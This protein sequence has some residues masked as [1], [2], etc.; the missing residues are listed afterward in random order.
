[1][2]DLVTLIGVDGANPL[3]FMASLGLLRVIRDARKSGRLSFSDDGMF[4]ARV[5]VD[6][7]ART[8]PEL[9]ADD[10]AR[11]AGAA[12]LGLRY[13]KTEKNGTKVVADLKAPPD[14]FRSFMEAAIEAW[15]T[16]NLDPAA[17]ATAFGTSEARDG[18]GVSTKPTAFHF[19]AANQTFL[20]IAEE[21]RGRVTADWARRS[22]FE[23]FAAEPGK[24]LRWDPGADRNWALM[25][26]NPNVEGTQ[27][28]APL[29]WL[30]VR[31][32]AL[33]PT[34]PVKDRIVT[35]AVEGTRADD[36]VFAW[37]MWSAPAGPA[38][39]AALLAADWQRV[40]VRDRRA[41][42]II[43]LCRSAVRRSSQGFGNFGPASIEP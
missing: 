6:F 24:N 36:Y 37:P 41:R 29:E 32:L 10:A 42:G 34:F 23:G 28:D 4:R 43:A 39:V 31:G 8:L 9:V 33:L 16:G 13:E 3:G 11:W 40:S 1:M 17:Y 7:D 2:S 19:T 14:V 21:T 30:A 25:A 20:G 35:T 22:L 26:S 38:T 15:Q 12:A 27:V 18:K 5:T